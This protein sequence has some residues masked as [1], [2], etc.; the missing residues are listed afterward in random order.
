MSFVYFFLL[1]ATLVLIQCLV[2]GTRMVYSFPP[3]AIAGVAALL[4][5]VSI[6]RPLASTYVY[7][8][9]SAILL[10]GYV[11]IRAWYSPN[12]YLARPDAFMAVGCLIIYLLT[13]LYLVQ[14]RFRGWVVAVLLLVALVHVG[15]GIVQFKTGK[16][17]MLF[18]FSDS[19]AYPGR[20]HGMLICPNHLAGFLEAV[21]LLGLSFTFWGRH[22][23]AV[24]L[25]FGYA[26]LVCFL[27]VAISGSRGGYLSTVF[28]LLVFA[29]LLLWMVRV[30]RDSRFW[31][32]LSGT[33]VVLAVFL[34]VAVGL[35]QHSRP[36]N[37]RLTR[38]TTASEDIRWYN[39]L[40]S[41]DQ[42]KLSP[43]LGT[44]SGTHLYYGRLF[45]RIQIQSDPEHS[46]NDYLELLSE[47]GV[48]GGILAAVFLILHAVWGLRTAKEM[49]RRR[50][51]CGLPLTGSD[52]LALTLGALGAVA[53]II[54]HSVVDFNLHIP[55][56][57]LLF[58]FIFGV[59]AS[60]GI[61]PA[62]DIRL[63]SMETLSRGLLV[64]LGAGLLA[65]VTGR[66][67]S[68]LFT[69]RSLMALRDRNYRECIQLAALAIE[70]DP[71]N[72]WNYF[73][74]GEAN[75]AWGAGM[76]YYALRESQ[77][78][79]AIAAYREGLKHFPQDMNLWTRLGQCLDATYQFEDADDAYRNAIANDPNLG[80]LY[81]YYGAHL[82]LTGEVEGAKKCEDAAH[83]MG[84]ERIQEIGMGTPPSFLNSGIT[85]KQ[86]PS[87]K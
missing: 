77:F 70:K 23:I 2:G 61:H 36:I 66:Y 58:A 42:F 29:G 6:R 18:G 35:M 37:Q 69:N 63:R 26:T 9:G 38:I 25:L 34:S 57:A 10:A 60:P 15:V 73:Y 72:P 32:A 30:H 68:E 44:G 64:L 80:I 67:Q 83:D 40:A 81:A 14:S 50:F 45:R 85:E 53:A 49:A 79:K 51:A 47:Y 27:G 39:W 5:V 59:L 41:V 21:G 62:A 16:P 12:P 78:L 4:S 31:L 82:R 75:R 3:Y 28:A 20:A 56:N 65:A 17:F 13:S 74:Q 52:T 48:V 76:P 1:S 8:L 24:K 87:S 54:A 19:G 43:L 55:G 84:A 71:L 11:V 46:H 22:R 33:L 7:C 86:P